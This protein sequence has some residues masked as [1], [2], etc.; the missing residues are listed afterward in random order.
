MAPKKGSTPWNK[1]LKTSD[2]RAYRSKRYQN[3]KRAM[4]E[5]NR[6]WKLNNPEASKKIARKAQKKAHLKKAYNLTPK[7]HSAKL[8][9]QSNLCGLCKQ[10]FV[11][12]PYFGRLAPVLDHNHTT[13]KLRSFLHNGCNRGL[14]YFNE[15]P[16]LLRRAA[17]YLEESVPPNIT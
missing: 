1:G 14:G 10:P 8:A 17:E 2:G 9:S 16:E 5:K 15:S 12:D 3:N 6:L 7:E 13:G 4:D 11:A